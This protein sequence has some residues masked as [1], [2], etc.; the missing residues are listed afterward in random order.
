M[1]DGY[2]VTDNH[3]GKNVKVAELIWVET[4]GGSWWPAQVVSEDAVSGNNK[5]LKTSSGEVP[6]R[7]YGS[8]KFLYVDGQKCCSDFEIILEQNNGSHRDI[9]LK[10][11]EQARIR[12]FPR[13]Q[14]HGKKVEDKAN[15]KPIKQDGL[16]KKAKENRSSVQ[17]EVLT[18]AG[19]RRLRVMRNLGLIAPSGSPYHKNG[20]V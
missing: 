19:A 18:E 7:L 16:L 15:G 2:D 12:S 17:A 1:E 6:V 5:P 8:Y 3:L 10:A 9:F 4:N 14:K 20:R 13:L 11:L